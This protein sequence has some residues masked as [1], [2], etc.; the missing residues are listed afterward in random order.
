MIQLRLSE[1]NFE[2]DVRGL[3]MAFYPGEEIQK[4]DWYAG[5]LPDVELPEEA[6]E[7]RRQLLVQYNMVQIVMVLN[8]QQ[9]EGADPKTYQGAIPVDLSDRAATKSALKRLL[10]QLLSQDTGK[11]LPW[12]T[13]TGIRP[14]KIAMGLLEEGCSEE[15]V[16]EYMQKEYLVGEEKTALS[17][18]IAKRE[19]RVLQNIDYENGYSM[20]IGIPFCPTT[21]LYCSFTSYPFSKWAKRA[22][23]YVEAVEKEIKWTAEAFKDKKLNTVYFGGGTPTTLTA[24]QLDRLLTCVEEHFDF[25]HLQ[26][27]TVEAGRPDSITRE[28]LEVL[29]KH[30]V[31]RIS[32]NPQTMKQETLDLIG[33]HHTVEQIKEVFAMARE[34]GFDNINMDLILGLPGETIDD[35]RNTM[36]ELKEMAPDNITVHSLAIKRAARLNIFWEKYAHMSME[37]SDDTMAVAAAVSEELGLKPY[38]LYRQKN[39]AGNLENVGYATPGKEG[40]Y[41]ILIM[42]EKQSI[43]AIG[44]GATTKAVYKDG[45]IERANNVKDVEL[46]MQQIDEMIERKK[47]LFADFL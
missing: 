10:Y 39:M 27:Y 23:E 41:N 19:K 44:A 7:W 18:D 33:R 24:E 37:N 47:K 38:Y 26:E 25:S 35:V 21:C 31:G 4:V 13:L 3:L 34:L 12:G 2:Y 42:E 36:A 28:K 14:T 17:I 5:I 15:E 43:V 32:I 6:R 40:I 11:V 20:Y 8:C 30:N 29:K 1:E 45:R 16:A 9:E 22:D 46:Y